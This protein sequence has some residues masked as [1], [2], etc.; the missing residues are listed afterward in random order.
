LGERLAPSTSST[1]R[2]AAGRATGSPVSIGS[3]PSSTSSRARDRKRV[4]AEPAFE[5]WD[6][7]RALGYY[8]TLAAVI[9]TQ[10]AAPRSATGCGDSPT[11]A[12]S[13]C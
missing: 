4:V 10:V 5:R 6:G 2:L 9:D 1:P 8:L 11:P 13:P 3:R 7:R 12:W